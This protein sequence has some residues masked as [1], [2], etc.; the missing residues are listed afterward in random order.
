MEPRLLAAAI[1]LGVSLL[2]LIIGYRIGFRKQL[3]L[4]AGLDVARVRDSDG[5]ARW[6]GTGL[7]SIGALDLLISLA[8]FSASVATVPAILAYVVVS[9]VGAVVLLLRMPRYLS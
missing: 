7:L 5:L 3:S 4:I 8:L 6:I 1:L 9:L 2:V